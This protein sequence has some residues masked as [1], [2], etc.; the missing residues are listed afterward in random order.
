MNYSRESEMN[1]KTGIYFTSSIP[2]WEFGNLRLSL[3][4]NFYREDVFVYGDR[5]EL[6]LRAGISKNF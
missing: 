4:Q 1:K 6:I 2:V 3:Q 5:D